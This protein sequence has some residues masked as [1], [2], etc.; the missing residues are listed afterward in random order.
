MTP[1]VMGEMLAR[2]DERT[3]NLVKWME[4]SSN[5]GFPRCADRGARLKILEE[6]YVWW[7]GLLIKG[8]LGAVFTS[9][10]AAIIMKL[11]GWIYITE[12][13]MP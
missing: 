6:N 5:G 13:I 2:I 1:E 12:S 4:K 3:E 7:K 10:V 11:S 8:G 9:V